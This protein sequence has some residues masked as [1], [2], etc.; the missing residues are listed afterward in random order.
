MNPKPKLSYENTLKLGLPYLFSLLVVAG[1]TAMLLMF[2]AQLNT[3]TVALLYLLPVLV[4]TTLWGLGAGI[5]CGFVTFL[6]YNFFF[7]QPYH[8]FEV[9]ESQ[10]ITAL[11]IFLVVAILVSQLVGRAKKGLEAALAREQESTRLY[12]L[13]TSLVGVSDLKEIAAVIAKKTAETFQSDAVEIRVENMRGEGLFSLRNGATN[14]GSPARPAVVAPLETVR[15]FLGELHIWREKGAF[16]PT[17]TRL[18]HIFSAQSALALERAAL[19]NAE[20]RAQ[21][22]EESDRLKSALLSSVSHEFRTPLVTIKAA[23][24]SLLNGQVEWDSAARRDLLEAVDEEADHLNH[25]LGNL[26]DMSRIEAGAMKPELQWNLLSEIVEHATAR[27]H[28]SLER[29]TLRVEIPEELPLIP[30]DF[31]RLEQVFKNLISNSAKYAPPGSEI[32]IQAR[33]LEDNRLLVQVTNQGPQVD[34]Q[35]LERIFDKF[36]RV[37]N[38][39]DVSG[40]GLGLS[41]CKGIIE[42]HG[43]KIW[44]ENQP[45]GFVFKFTLPLLKD[46]AAPPVVEAH[47]T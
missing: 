41:I 18:L 36:F 23:S 14:P 33:A 25:L 3:S 16:S 26:L 37:T 15:G 10:D 17:E 32:L 45:E 2:R 39:D 31:V 30:V 21:V 24:T 11:V 27:I 9:H 13:S 12:E 1:M 5:L 4:S 40:T 20:R 29:H 8:T 28:R 47:E 38:A 44:A 34:P 22:L 19:A 6:S 7:L 46:G 43:G 42:A 35:H